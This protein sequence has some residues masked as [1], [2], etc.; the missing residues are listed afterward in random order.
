MVLGIGNVKTMGVQDFTKDFSRH[1]RIIHFIDLNELV[2]RKYD[3]MAKDEV[4]ALFRGSPHT[5][6][7]GAVVNA[8][9]VISGLKA[10]KNNPVAAYFLPQVEEIPPLR[11]W[12][13][14][15]LMG[16]IEIPPVRAI[17]RRPGRVPPV[18]KGTSPHL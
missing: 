18:T 16:T 4:D 12:G 6:W 17:S 7:A 1:Y 13:M 14:H 10:L 15:Q 11:I 9:T 3:A 2:A 5:S 8:E